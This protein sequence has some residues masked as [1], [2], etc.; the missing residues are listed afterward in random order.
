MATILFLINCYSSS[1]MLASISCNVFMY[2]YLFYV[3]FVLSIKV[4]EMFLNYFHHHSIL[5]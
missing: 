4:S 5:K 2:N 1:A 3:V